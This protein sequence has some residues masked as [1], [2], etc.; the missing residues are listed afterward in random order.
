[1]NLKSCGEILD[2]SWGLKK[3]LSTNVSNNFIDLIYKKGKSAGAYGGKILGAGGGGYFIFFCE[4]S[5]QLNLKK[6]LKNLTHIKFKFEK[7]GSKII[8]ND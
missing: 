6:R 4:Q 8:Y 1:M 2:E 5:K 7:H 3:Q